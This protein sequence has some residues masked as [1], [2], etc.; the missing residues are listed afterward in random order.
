MNGHSCLP[1]IT[2]LTAQVLG[3]DRGDAAEIGVY[4]GQSAKLICQQLPACT[5]HLFDTCSG[6]PASEWQDGHDLHRPGEFLVSEETIRQRL[7]GLT[8]WRLHV[9]VFPLTAVECRLRFVHVDCD[10]AKTCWH[11]I[12]WAWPRMVRGGI[13][14]FDD[15]GN[16]QCPG[17]TK[18]V[19]KWM[20][21]LPEKHK[22]QRPKTQAWAIRG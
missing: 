6:L 17:L 3:L 20:D 16:R 5:V 10:L 2:D 12:D 18:V 9:G 22:T 4:G 11:A 21:A 1:L 7:S 8:N 13:L 14:Y 19:D 15:Y